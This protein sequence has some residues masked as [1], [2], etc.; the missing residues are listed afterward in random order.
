MQRLPR[1][2]RFT[3]IDQMFGQTGTAQ[4]APARTRRQRDQPESSDIRAFFRRIPR[5]A[6]AAPS[7][8]RAAPTVEAARQRARMASELHGDYTTEEIMPNTFRLSTSTRAGFLRFLRERA[9]PNSRYRLLMK[10]PTIPTNRYS[11]GTRYIQVSANERLPRKLYEELERARVHYNTFGEIRKDS[12]GEFFVDGSQIENAWDMI[13]H[14]DIAVVFSP[15]TG[16]CNKRNGVTRTVVNDMVLMSFPSRD[17]NC[18]LACIRQMLGDDEFL[19]RIN[20]HRE[21]AI[22]IDKVYKTLRA[23]VGIKGP[24]SPDQ[25][26][27]VCQYLECWEDGLIYEG[28]VGEKTRLALHAGH[29]FMF[30]GMDG[31]RQ[32]RC[33]RWV[34]E[35]SDHRCNAARLQFFQ[36]EI[37]NNE[38]GFGTITFD[39]ETRNDLNHKKVAWT[40]DA[41]GEVVHR[42][43]FFYQVPTEISWYDGRD[44]TNHIGLDCVDRFLE[45]LNDESR[46]GRFK[47]LKSHNGSRFD[48]AFI[49][50]RILERDSE[51][52]TA[53]NVL[54]KGTQ[55]LSIKWKGHI[56]LDTMKH[57]AFS[58][59]K[60]CKDFKVET[61]K[62]KEV[63][64]DGRVMGSMDLC[65]MRKHLG[66]QE[67][68]DSLSEDER[69]AY[70]AYCNADVV[71]LY[72]VDQKYQATLRDA[73]RKINRVSLQ[74][75]DLATYDQ[76]VAENDKEALD[77]MKWKLAVKESDIEKLQM[78]VTAPGM[79]YSLS[80]I[81]NRR[82]ILTKDEKKNIKKKKTGNWW[83]PDKESFDFIK[84]C[85]IGGISHVQHPGFHKG[86]I[87]GIDVVSLYPATFIHGSFPRGAP[88]KT[89]TWVKGHLGLYTIR[90]VKSPGLPIGAIPL[91]KENGSL[92]WSAQ[93][94]PEAHV[95]SCD[96]ITMTELGY[97][98]E[99]VEGLYWKESWNPFREMISVF[100]DI[101][102]EQDR[103]KGTEDY[104]NALREVAKLCQN[105]FF[106]KLLETCNSYEYKVLT[107]AE[108]AA[109]EWDA[110][111]GEELR[112]QNGRFILK[113]VADKAPCPVQFGVFVLGQSRRIMQRYFNLVGRE[114]VI[115]SETDSIYLK[116]EKLGPLY[117]ST[118]PLLRISKEY[119]DMEVE[120]K[121]ITDAYFLEKK[122]YC[123]ETDDG[124]YKY[125][126]KG[127]PKRHLT[128]DVYKELYEKRKV[129]FR[130][131]LMF[132]RILFDSNTAPGIAVGTIMKTV[133]AS[134]EYK[135]YH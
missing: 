118:Q 42:S 6:R 36:H 84:K 86:P 53:R 81:I 89:N 5:R 60:L 94:I 79:M 85:K 95:T 31:F 50:A 32:C 65:L 130:D 38:C 10:S 70:I 47:V 71:S 64:V 21:K 26:K 83:T 123:I 1:N 17:N 57:L 132:K 28:E 44:V 135:E 41:N 67:F 22:G 43:E 30:A 40:H 69:R 100:K 114:N 63:V 82:H 45:Y 37:A 122:L 78:S 80:K 7:L 29:W 20:K 56:F 110:E 76:A 103:L 2:F 75:W 25:V 34:R 99:V 62:I 101:K 4:P 49:L 107:Q 91:R 48:N 66:P 124:S 8:M 90:N 46:E 58:L 108:V 134:R 102:M 11:V 74:D 93:E 119:G 126:F 55:I 59:E 104:N 35:S 54:I 73:F 72:Q 106:G 131:I 14:F 15:N 92:D 68:I 77:A 24:M 23:A 98:F 12:W 127:V 33:G 51:Y 88:E 113:R 96:L 133:V 18:A 112:F 129:E 52:D 61:A 27:A 128:P 9:P 87:A 111:A 39:L 16:G 117:A 116:T 97:T 121:N 120:M 125:A 105:A 115:A 19:Q 109:V 13:S 3:P